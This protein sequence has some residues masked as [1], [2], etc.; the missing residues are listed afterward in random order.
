[1]YRFEVSGVWDKRGGY[2]AARA[3]PPP[4]PHWCGGFFSSKTKILARGVETG[5]DA[6]MIAQRGLI[7]CS[8]NSPKISKKA[9]DK[10]ARV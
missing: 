2:A 6:G 3:Y 9:L 5:Q 10:I 8:R 1:M 7:C 4:T